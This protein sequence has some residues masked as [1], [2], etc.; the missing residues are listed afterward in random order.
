VSLRIEKRR[1]ADREK[2][3]KSLP[4]YSADAYRVLESWDIRLI[5]EI[6]EFFDAS[7]IAAYEQISTRANIPDW[8]WHVSVSGT[9]R[10]PRWDEFAHVVHSFRPG[11]MFTIALP[12]PQFW[13]NVAQN[14]LHAWEIKD[15]NLEDLW[16]MERRGDKPS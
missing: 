10:V 16:R 3:L 2:L 9:E 8:R 1:R 12:P 14:C 5:N 15:A 4:M 7:V 13:I 11:V 6:Y